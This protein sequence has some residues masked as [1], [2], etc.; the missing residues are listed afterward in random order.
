[1]DISKEGLAELA[2]YEG[3]CTA[4]YLDSGGVWTFGV[5]HTHYD[6]YP[7]PRTMTKGLDMP[8]EYVFELYQKKIHRYV[9]DVNKAITVPLTQAQFDALVSF[10][11]N[12]G[13]IKSATLTKSIN[14]GTDLSTIEHNFMMWVKD[15]GKT[16]QGLIN[17]RKA[18]FRLYSTGTYSRNGMATVSSADKNGKEINR[19]TINIVGY[20][21]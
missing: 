11:Y 7:D 20:I 5:G 1:M 10:H 14:N 6:G 9:N 13:A 18:E 8:L 4:P 16:V 21:K 17:R 2:G 12:T 3:V 15:N 19:R